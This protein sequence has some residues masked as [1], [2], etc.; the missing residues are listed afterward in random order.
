MDRSKDGQME[1][2]IDGKLDRWNG[3]L[4]RWRDRKMDICINKD[5]YGYVM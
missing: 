4:D 1:S 5:R 3:K 2:W